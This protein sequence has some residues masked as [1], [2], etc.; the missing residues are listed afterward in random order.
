MKH[1]ITTYAPRPPASVFVVYCSSY[2]NHYQYVF[3]YGQELLYE[4]I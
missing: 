3:I 4:H 1:P 2:V